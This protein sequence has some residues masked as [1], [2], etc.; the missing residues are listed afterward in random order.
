MDNHHRSVCWN[1]ST[2]CF[3]EVGLDLLAFLLYMPLFYFPVF[4]FFQTKGPFVFHHCEL[5]G[6]K[7]CQGF[8]LLAFDWLQIIMN[9]LPFLFLSVGKGQK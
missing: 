8:N 5:F 2:L 4:P 1:L 6:R 9:D 7:M 3:P